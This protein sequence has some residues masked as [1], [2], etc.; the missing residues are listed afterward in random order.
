MDNILRDIILFKQSI[1]E[2][3]SY[4]STNSKHEY[5]LQIVPRACDK[6][7]FLRRAKR[8]KWIENTLTNV[9]ADGS[10]EDGLQCVLDYM[11]RYKKD[12]TMKVMHDLGIMPKVMDKYG[13]RSCWHPCH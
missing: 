6:Q 2:Q 10:V 8:S 9:I 3:V 4:Q 5:D 13:R 11:L 1:G 7:Q 12:E